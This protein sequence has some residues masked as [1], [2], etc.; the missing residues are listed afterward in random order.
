M[1]EFVEKLQA[2]GGSKTTAHIVYQKPGDGWK[3]D[4]E[5]E[6][7]SLTYNARGDL[8]LLSWQRDPRLEHPAWRN[9]RLDRIRSVKAGSKKFNPRTA[10]TIHTG[11]VTEFVFGVDPNVRESPVSPEERYYKAVESSIADGRVDAAEAAQLKRLRG[12]LTMQ[13]LRALH[14]QLYASELTEA[15]IDGRITASEERHLAQVARLLAALGWCPTGST[16]RPWWRRW[17]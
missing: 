11:E 5:I 6:P 14:A 8:I 17:F 10:I 13:Q 2:L 1:R 4:R 16:E 15:A 7:Y 12:E 9:F 3:T